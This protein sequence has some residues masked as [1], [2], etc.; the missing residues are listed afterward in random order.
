MRAKQRN[1][2]RL[3][4]DQLAANL[5]GVAICGSDAAINWLDVFWACPFPVQFLF[6]CNLGRQQAI[7][8][9]PL[10]SLAY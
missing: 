7:V 6:V 8:Y 4:Q 10:T 9:V 2:W 1:R 5:N 3:V